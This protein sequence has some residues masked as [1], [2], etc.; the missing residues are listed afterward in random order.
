MKIKLWIFLM[1]FYCGWL[2]NN[3][4]AIENQFKGECISLNFQ[5]VE[6]RAVLQVI[7]NVSEFNL[8][9]SDS[10]KGNITLNLKKVPWDQALDIILKSKNL[11]QRQIGNVIMIGPID[12][13]ATREKA[14]LENQ[15]QV[16]EL[17]PLYS[18]L[19]Q[20]HYAKAEDLAVLLKEKTNSLMTNRGN[21][22]VDKRTN[23]LLI[24]DTHNKLNEIRSLLKKLDIP[25]RQVEISTQIIVADEDLEKTLGI[26]FGATGKA[27]QP[28]QS[29]GLFSDLSASPI[30]NAPL[31]PALGL[32][33]AKLPNGLLLDLELQA[34]EYAQK[35]K[36]IARPRLLTM[37]QTTACIE[38][39]I[40][41]PYLQNTASGANYVSYKTAGL[42]L[43]VTPHITPNNKIALD[44]RIS[45][46]S[47]GM[48]APAGPQINTNRIQ[49]RV[50]VDNGETIVLG[51]VMDIT[52][53][54]AKTKVP[55]LGDIPGIGKLFQSKYSKYSP[56]E[57]II[58]LTP[59]IL[60]AKEE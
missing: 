15:K 44:V 13:M 21:V 5:D 53:N 58:F 14:E 39:G 46:D 9:V 60:Q 47:V 57:L 59:K 3:T 35:T 12:E 42:K 40:D 10:V 41:I 33:L 48:N 36:T 25:V 50:L 1:G 19:L 31:T 51:G 8:I 27:L 26:R 18:E 34:L 43:E 37:D 11:T 7:S 32:A 38:Q 45:K 17:G 4:L 55:F 52:D 30:A 28:E 49:T 24:Q 2:P 29:K 20:I 6:V 54:K 56:K 23:T 16:E 22:T